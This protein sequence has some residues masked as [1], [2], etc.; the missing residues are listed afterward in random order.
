MQKKYYIDDSLNKTKGKKEE[1]ILAMVL[2]NGTSATLIFKS[3]TPHETNTH[4]M[5]T[6]V[7]IVIGS[8][9]RSHFK[10]IDISEDKDIQEL[11][12][13]IHD[14]QDLFENLRRKYEEVT[15]S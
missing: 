7:S 8:Y 9:C 14:V 11:H 3:K 2:D 4:E 10:E 15:S 5:M 6:V 13:K 1:S 12:K